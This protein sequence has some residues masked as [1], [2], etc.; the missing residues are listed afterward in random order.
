M[1]RSL[2]VRLIAVSALVA[3]CAIAATAWLAART[4]TGAIKQEQGQVFADDGTIYQGLLAYAAAHPSWDGVAGIVHTYA[5]DTGRRVVLATPQGKVIASSDADPGKLP[6]QPSVVIDPLS[7]DPGLGVQSTPDRIDPAAVGPY[8]LPPDERTRLTSAARRVL[9]CVQQHSSLGTIETSPGGHPRVVAD[10]PFA[11]TRCNGAGLEKPTKTEQA[12]L[13]KLQG[14]VNDCLGRSTVSA[15]AAQLTSLS[16]TFA[17][18][19]SAA[20]DTPT[21]NCLNS[22]RREQLTPYVAPAAWL[23]ITEKG[24]D[25]PPSGFTLSA[26]NQVRLAEV[27]GAILVLTVVATGL[28]SIR[29][30]RPLHALTGAAQRMEAGEAGARVRVKGKDEIARLARAFNDM[31]EARE[32]LEVARKA[33]VSDIAHELRTPLANIRG[34][35][36]ATQDGVSRLDDELVVSL[37]EEA[38]HLQHI[39]DDLQDLALADAGALRVHPEPID[40]NSLLTQLAAAHTA[41]ADTAGVSLFVRTMPD[42]AVT[43]DP[44]RL[45]QALD[46]LVSNA[47]RHTPRGGSVTVSATRSGPDVVFSVTDTGVGIASADLPHVFDRFWRADKARTR[48]PSGGSGL[49]LAIVRNLAQAHGGTVTVR[50]VVGEGSTFTLRFPAEGLSEG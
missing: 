38:L 22:A 35:L 5:A 37:L 10:D 41:R 7:V 13:T 11:L 1:R 25:Q 16:W 40:A 31:S 28:A 47:V 21:Q 14:L 23:Y 17:G 44:V 30:I 29:L 49:G 45:R 33:M 15:P 18:P 9:E 12:A 8:N 46:N 39:V 26:D 43:A 24:S 32:K 34:W 2:L 20:T 50:S 6:P 4:T 27:A 19:E 42:S 3:V 48:G 36:E